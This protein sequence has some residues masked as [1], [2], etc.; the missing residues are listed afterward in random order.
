[1]SEVKHASVWVP[2]PFPLQGRLPSRVEQ[3]QQN[4]LRQCEQ[5]R[6]YQDAL[7]LA[8]GYRVTPPCCRPCTSACSSTVPAMDETGNAMQPAGLLRALFDDQVHASRAWFLYS[9]GREWMGSYFRERMVFFGEASRREVALNPEAKATM[10]ARLCP[11]RNLSLRLTLPSWT[12]N[13]WQKRSKPSMRTG[14]PITPRS[15]R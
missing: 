14:T 10:L 1:M 7:C 5:E 9:I 4:I 11:P 8:A 3:V 12:P 6:G 15:A 13:V 2:P